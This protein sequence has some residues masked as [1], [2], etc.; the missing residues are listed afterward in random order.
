[1]TVR[2]DPGRLAI[3]L[4][5][6]LALVGVIVVMA[7]MADGRKA[8][9]NKSVR[10]SNPLSAELRRCGDLGESARVDARCRA[11]W[12][13]SRARFFGETGS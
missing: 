10:P 12:D 9:P 11:A 6:I 5:A 4:C 2:P 8:A 1:M 7:S 13:E 3:A